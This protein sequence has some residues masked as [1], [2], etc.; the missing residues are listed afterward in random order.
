MYYY[1]NAATLTIGA[2]PTSVSAVTVTHAAGRE[3][4]RRAIHTTVAGGLTEQK[5]DTGTERSENSLLREGWRAGHCVPG[6]EDGQYIGVIE[7]KTTGRH[8]DH[9]DPILPADWSGTAKKRYAVTGDALSPVYRCSTELPRWKVYSRPRRRPAEHG[10]N[11]RRDEHGLLRC[12]PLGWPDRK[13][14]L[15][16]GRAAA[17]IF[18]DQSGRCRHGS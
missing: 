18:S 1:S 11:R 16:L 6:G 9:E 10:S 14:D 15:L 4:K 13:T 7:S 17:N 5:T 12:G 8:H 2:L 3:R